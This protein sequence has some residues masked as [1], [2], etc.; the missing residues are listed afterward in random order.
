MESRQN[1]IHQKTPLHEDS[2]FKDNNENLKSL[3]TKSLIDNQ[4]SQD[5]NPPNEIIQNSLEDS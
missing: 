2:L 3:Q 4:W 1:F 5:T